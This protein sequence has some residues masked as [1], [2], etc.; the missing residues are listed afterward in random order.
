M[1]ASKF[2]GTAVIAVG[3]LFTA[4]VQ[5]GKPIDGQYIVVLDRDKLTAPVA[6]V[7]QLL[8]GSVGGGEIIQVYEHSLAG[9][10]VRLPAIAAATLEKNPLV[11]Y[12]EKDQLMKLVDTQ[13]N[14]PSYGLDRVDQRALP[15]DRAY[16]Y[17]GSAGSGVHVYI[18]DTGLRSTHVDFAG[19]IGAGR[20]FG[21]SG[22]GLLCD[23]L[24]IGCPP[25]DPNNTEDCN[26]HG[27]HVSGTA[28]GTTHGVAKR[29]TVH[30]VRVFGCGN[31]TATSTIIAG[32]DWV[33]GN[34]Q[35]P[36]AAN[37][38]LGGGASTAMDTAVRNM[39]GSGVVAAVAAGNDNANAC[40]SSPARV[41]EAIT[42][43]STTNTDA[44]SSFSNFG[45]CV[46][47]FAPG[48]SIV[49]AGI[50]GDTSE[51]SLSGTS[52]AA[53]HVA[54]AAARHLGAGASAGSVH[55]AIVSSAT[56]GVVGNPGSGSPNRLLYLDPNGP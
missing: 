7:A 18:I 39:I 45:S 38:S 4:G 48:S 25:A 11:E 41:A 20:N 13:A 54:G 3:A 50:A 29:A 2:I 40:N 43:G 37:L 42:V 49:S 6:Q 8:A 36:A 21:P 15:L 27:T 53:P 24:G 55:N 47:L 10:A 44:R 30:A 31:S 26:G 32:V 1:Q 12:I 51:D 46:D 28:L 22:G 17:P 23:L 9:F 14:P 52:M 33:T 19:R 34:R 16:N 35:L 56:T 5:A